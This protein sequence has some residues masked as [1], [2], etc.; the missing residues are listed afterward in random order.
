MVFQQMIEVSTRAHGVMHDLTDKVRAVIKESGVTTGI[1]NVSVVG[2]TASIS[3]IEHLLV[4]L[5]KEDAVPFPERVGLRPQ[6]HCH[7]EH[8]SADASHQFGL[9]ARVFL[10]ME[11]AYNSFRRFGVVVLNELSFYAGLF[12]FVTAVRFHEESTFVRENVRRYNYQP[13]GA[14]N[15][16]K[17]ECHVLK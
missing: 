1:V 11:S 17:C 9:F 5:R 7:I 4:L 6:I 16:G 12:K 2:S 8:L 14:L 13:F 3:T 10:K 15:S